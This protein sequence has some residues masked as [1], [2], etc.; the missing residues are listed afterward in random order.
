[1]NSYAFAMIATVALLLPAGNPRVDHGAVLPPANHVLYTMT[2]ASDGNEVLTYSRHPAT[3]A[4]TFVGA[5][6]TGGDGTGMGL[7]N[8]GG[9]ILTEDRNFVLVVNAGSNTVSSLRVTGD[10]LVLVDAESSGGTMPV[11]ITESGGL[12]YVVNAGG[13]GN[14]S[15]LTLSNDGSLTP[16]ARSTRPLSGA[17]APAPA[18]IEFSPDGNWLVVTEKMTNIIDLYSV[19]SDGLASDP[20]E[21]PSSGMTPFGFSFDGSGHLIVSEAFG[22]A[23][24]ASAVSSYAINPDGSLSVISASVPTTETAA[25]WIAITKNGRFAYTTNTGSGTITGYAV[26]KPTATLTILDADGV[27]ASTGAGTMP[28]DIVLSN[29]G[30]FA[31]V[32]NAGE[33]TISAFAV[34]AANG[35][36]SA[37]GG[38][39]TTGLPAGT[40]GLAAQ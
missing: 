7:G 32:L 8:Q 24:G 6:D 36:L 19:G 40:N 12:V 37:V 3:G 27:T 30:R 38:G 22:G 21:N 26:G 31:Y 2:N 10:G 1:M 39:V 29:D 13:A 17:A 9:V 16:V 20:I 15:G 28:I 5:V 11:S 35:S 4:L 23:A 25:C 14:I 34:N 33:L 18:Q